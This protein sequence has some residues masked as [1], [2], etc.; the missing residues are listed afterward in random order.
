MERWRVQRR[1]QSLTRSVE[2]AAGGAQKLIAAR[3]PPPVGLEF[4]VKHL[5]D[6]GSVSRWDI[7]G[8]VL[9][10]EYDTWCGDVEQQQVQTQIFCP[11]LD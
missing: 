2:E 11:L 5:G 7:I 10:C 9:G 8:T 1:A 6:D 3:L 4:T